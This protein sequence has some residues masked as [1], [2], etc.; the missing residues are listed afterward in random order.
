MLT[1]RSTYDPTSGEQGGLQIRCFGCF[2]VLRDGRVV[3]TWRRDKAKLLMKH[4]VAR[5]RSVHRDVLF[6]L[7][8][9]ELDAACA[10]RNLRVT[11]HALRRA[12]DGAEQLDVA[13]TS[14]L[15]RGD[16]YELNPG[17]PVWIDTEA[18]AR[19]VETARMYERQGRAREATAAYEAAVALYRDH[20]LV[21]DLYAEW[22][23]LPREQLKDQ[24]LLIVTRLADAALA[25]GDAEGCITYSHRVLNDDPTREDAYQRLMYCHARQGRRA[26]AMRWF[27]LCQE[28]L[29]RDLNVEP[30]EST[31]RLAGQ[32]A[33]G[34]SEPLFAMAGRRSVTDWWTLTPSDFGALRTKDA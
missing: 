31:R 1:A 7:L 21:D 26:R 33:A 15:T 13:T 4:L 30:A 10:A 34:A 2:E 19:L 5:R 28:T 11:L 12:I 29:R 22:T 18:F 17:T 6:E 14:V 16:A 24:Y 27:E 8:W 32:I 3:Q 25:A 20:Y 9:P 23:L